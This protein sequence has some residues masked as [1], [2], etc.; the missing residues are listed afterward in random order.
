MKR[1]REG[2]AALDPTSTSERDFV[3]VFW[4]GGVVHLFLVVQV[5]QSETPRYAHPENYILS[6]KLN[7]A[8][9][10]I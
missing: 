3:C 5:S 2:S 7:E 10:R 8:L 6:F 1:D 4:G 9:S